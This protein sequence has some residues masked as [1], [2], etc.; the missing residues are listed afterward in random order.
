MQMKRK[1]KQAEAGKVLLWCAHRRHPD[2]FG[3]FALYIKVY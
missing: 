1:S 3:F 2:D